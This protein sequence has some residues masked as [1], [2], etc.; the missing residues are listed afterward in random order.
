MINKEDGRVYS[1]GQEAAHLIGYVQTINAEELEE[2]EGEGY[3]STSLI[4]KSGLELAYEDTLRGIDGTDIYIVDENEN[5]IASLAK[6]EQ[7][8]GQDVKLTID[9]NLQKQ[10]YEQMKD[11]KGFFVIMEPK[12]RRTIS[13]S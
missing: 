5:R 8:D 7:K 10:V 9:S 6:Q 11:D 4:G 3:T 13:I 2:H 1:L 12:T